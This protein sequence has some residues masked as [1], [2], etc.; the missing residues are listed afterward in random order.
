MMEQS[1]APSGNIL[2]HLYFSLSE[3]SPSNISNTF[4]LEEQ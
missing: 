4:L 1:T 3:I 2:A